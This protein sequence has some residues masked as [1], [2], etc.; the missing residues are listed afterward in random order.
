MRININLE[1]LPDKIKKD[2][3]IET[4]LRF[5]EKSKKLITF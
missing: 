1:I 3:L 2:E 5:L 4:L